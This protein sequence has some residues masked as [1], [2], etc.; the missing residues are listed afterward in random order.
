MLRPGYKEDELIPDERVDAK[1]P[2]TRAVLRVI[3]PTLQSEV[4]AL[5]RRYKKHPHEDPLFN[6]PK[7]FSSR[8]VVET[9]FE[10]WGSND[11]IRHFLEV[12][13]SRITGWRMDLSSH[14]VHLMAMDDE[15]G[16]ASRIQADLTPVGKAI[17]VAGGLD[18]AAFVEFLKTFPFNHED[19]LP[20]IGDFYYHRLSRLAR[21]GVF[22]PRR[23]SM[24]NEDIEKIVRAYNHLPPSL[25]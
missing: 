25:T 18:E 16:Q 20:G 23:P 8:Q 11:K 24:P 22:A 19:I 3:H 7:P 21:L 15:I 14:G 17:V 2:S 10:R 1:F 4:Q 5:A 6:I 9:M 13:G 12:G